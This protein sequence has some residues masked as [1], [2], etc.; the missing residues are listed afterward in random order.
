MVPFDFK[1]VLN[2]LRGVEGPS[3]WD[4]N[5]E[6]FSL[7]PAWGIRLARIGALVI[8]KVKKDELPVRATVLTLTTL[9]SLAP[10]LVIGYALL[11]GL[12]FSSEVLDRLIALTAGMPDAFQ[13]VVQQVVQAVE[14]T[15]FAKLGGAGALLLFVLV[16]QTLSTIEKA[17]NRVWGISKNRPL[18]QKI[19][20]YISIVV[21]VPVLIATSLTLSAQINMDLLERSGAMRFAPG[22][23]AWLALSFLYLYMPN[24]RVRFLPALGSAALI[25]IAWMIWFRTYITLQPGVTR[26]NLLYGTLASVPIF[27]AWLYV[28]WI[29]VLMGAV[30]TYAMQTHESFT[31]SRQNHSLAPRAQLHMAVDLLLWSQHSFHQKGPPLSVESYVKKTGAPMGVVRGVIA[32][33]SNAGWLAE[34]EQKN[35]EQ[36]VLTRDIE[37]IALTDLLAEVAGNLPADLVLAEPANIHEQLER[38]LAQGLAGKT[39]AQL[40]SQN[41][42]I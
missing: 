27:L 21:I 32:T 38:W 25:T 22:F 34:I 15:D 24:T 11:R 35:E 16:V 20:H 42:A 6:K 39:V 31:E 18:T 28:G 10:L 4:L 36:W 37:R 17:F 26:L 5:P 40:D 23:V 13:V 9:M 1:K 29:I 12:G 3:I 30:V 19:T 7:I 33:L 8:R 14:Q 41:D 2:I